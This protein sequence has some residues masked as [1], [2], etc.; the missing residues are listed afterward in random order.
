MIILKTTAPMTAP[1]HHEILDDQILLMITEGDS[2]FR[3]EILAS[4]VSS[5]Q[6]IISDIGAAPDITARQA[7]AHKLK[8][9]AASVG[10]GVLQRMSDAIEH[11]PLGAGTGAAHFMALNTA[12]DA[13]KARI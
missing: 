4:F 7:K 8:G 11:D 10:A 1:A 3:N 2:G 13:I 9:L 12:L 6:E 5:A